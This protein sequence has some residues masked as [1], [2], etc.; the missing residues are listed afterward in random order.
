M[1]NYQD[2]SRPSGVASNRAQ[3]IQV[4][5]RGEGPRNSVRVPLFWI[6]TA[7]RQEMNLAHDGEFD[8]FKRPIFRP[9]G[10]REVPVPI[11]IGERVHHMVD[12]GQRVDVPDFMVEK[13]LLENSFMRKDGT[14]LYN[15]T[16]DFDYAMQVKNALESGEEIPV[17][18]EAPA[19]TLNSLSDDELE[20]ELAR[21]KVIAEQATKSTSRSRKNAENEEEKE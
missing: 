5:M 1:F 3:D 8:K 13:V 12:I 21:R 20:A 17:P 18:T 11:R 10:E 9:D 15:F 7:K 6:G 16:R 14:R 2:T 19:M 4:R